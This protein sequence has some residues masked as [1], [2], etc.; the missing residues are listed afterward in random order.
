MDSFKTTWK[1]Y[2]GFLIFLIMTS[3]ARVPKQRDKVYLIIKSI[4]EQF[5]PDSRTGIFK[6]QVTWEGNFWN[7]AGESSNSR[8]HHALID[9]LERLNLSYADHITELP[10]ADPVAETYGLINLSVANI[11]SEPAHSAELSTQ[12]LLGMPVRILKKKLG[13]FLLSTPDGYLG[14]TNEESIYSMDRETYDLSRQRIKIIFTDLT[15]ISYCEPDLQSV[16]VS[17]LVVGCVLDLTDSTGQFYEVQYPD[18]RKA[19]I[20]KSKVGILSKWIEKVNPDAISLTDA[21][22]KMTGFPYLW[23]GTSTKGMDCSGFTKTIYFMCGINLPRDADQQDRIG[24]LVDNKKEF[25]NLR[26]GDLLFFGNPPID[27]TAMAVVHVGMYIGNFQFIHCSGDVHL[28]SLN[29]EADNFDEYNLGRYLETR[30]ITG[31]RWQEE[32]SLSSVY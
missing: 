3:C 32:L 18:H 17:D 28:S 26:T 13:W 24:E 1:I 12:A 27:S 9:S 20:L 15:G 30:R 11:R 31:T 16:P 29:P 4:R 22:E 23:G 14:W 6:I 19:Y 2:A 7:L 8:A 21:A 5:V 25:T 10:D